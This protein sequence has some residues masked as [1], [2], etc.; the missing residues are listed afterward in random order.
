MNYKLGHVRIHMQVPQPP[1]IEIPLNQGYYQPHMAATPQYAMMP[2][3]PQ[4]NA[5]LALILAC[6]SIVAGGFCLAIPAIIVA[7]GAL[8][9]TNQFPGHPDAGNAKA[10]HLIGWIITGL[11]GVIFAFYLLMI[12]FLVSTEN[13]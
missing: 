11:Y 1:S 2:M 8:Q 12:I 3:W 10:A 13:I 4:T 7:K 9:I 6:V 5:T